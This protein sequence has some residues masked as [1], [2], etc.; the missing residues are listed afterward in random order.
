M[1][2]LTYHTIFIKSL[3]PE[4]LF[5]GIY[6]VQKGHLKIYGAWSKFKSAAI[7]AWYDEYLVSTLLMCVEGIWYRC[8]LFLLYFAFSMTSSILIS[9]DPMK[10]EFDLNSW[11]EKRD[12]GV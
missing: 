9:K 12:H 8:R 6:L 2:Q 7:L 1:Q 3:I 5:Y 10:Q 11:N 4:F